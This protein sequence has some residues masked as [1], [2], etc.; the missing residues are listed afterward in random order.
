M[1]V[2]RVIG[3]LFALIG[4]L[5]VVII[6]ALSTSVLELGGAPLVNWIIN[7]LI[8]VLA[9]FGGLIGFGTRATGA[10]V[11]IC[12]IV[13]LI[14]GILAYAI[15]DFAILFGQ[16]S[17]FSIYLEVGPW[18]GITLEAFFMIIG[19]IFIAASGK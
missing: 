7:L 16:Y 1:S 9:L 10:L 12:G 8:G 6:V 17:V 13:S 5:F 14:L 18:A 2:G 15:I 4:G 11:I 3:G 19:G